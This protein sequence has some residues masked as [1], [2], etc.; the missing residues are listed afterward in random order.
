MSNIRRASRIADHWYPRPGWRPGRLFDTWHILFDDLPEVR[1]LAGRAQDALRELPGLAKVPV[2]W[3][4]MTVQ[5]VGWSDELSDSQRSDVIDSVTE[6]MATVRQ[7]HA[8]FG[9]PL[10]K[11]E[12]LVLS[13]APVEALHGVRNRIRAG[14]TRALRVQPWEALEQRHGFLPHVSVAYAR[15]DA[16]AAPYAMALDKVVPVSA[17]AVVRHIALI[18]QERHFAPRWQYTWDEL[19]RVTLA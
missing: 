7:I 1:A 4:H 12:A 5:G 10:V 9:P 3:L 13:A 11:G 14:I 6:E 19:A 2:E 16:D 15:L 8:T 17:T 18:R